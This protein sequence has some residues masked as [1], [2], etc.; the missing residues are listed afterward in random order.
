MLTDV[1]DML[2]PTEREAADKWKAKHGQTCAAPRYIVISNV[3]GFR[4][5]LKVFC[6]RC[7]AKEDVT[8]PSR[9]PAPKH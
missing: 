2:K 1:S 9:D 4:Y 6:E 8:D 3:S 7:G 5:R